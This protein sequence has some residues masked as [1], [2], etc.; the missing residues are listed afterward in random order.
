VNLLVDFLIDDQDNFW[1][2][3]GES[4]FSI[5]MPDKKITGYSFPGDRKIKSG[6]LNIR[7]GK[8]SK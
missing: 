1:I 6:Y 2:L 3:Y 8:D 5:S 4:V 7:L